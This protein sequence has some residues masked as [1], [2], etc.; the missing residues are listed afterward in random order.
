VSTLHHMIPM[1]DGRWHY[2]RCL[3]CGKGDD[4]AYVHPWCTQ[5]PDNPKNVRDMWTHDL[6]LG[7]MSAVEK[8]FSDIH[9]RAAIAA[10]SKPKGAS[11]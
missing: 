6:S 4:A 7:P 2:S 3:Y 8:A 1:M 11:E 10:Q 9:S 5:H